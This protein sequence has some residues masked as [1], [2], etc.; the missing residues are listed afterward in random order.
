MTPR[1]Y[2][3]VFRAS[4]RIAAGKAR[5]MLPPPKCTQVGSAK[6][7]AF[8]AAMSYFGSL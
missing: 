7:F 4:F 1:S 8:T 6:V 5:K 2:R 3:P